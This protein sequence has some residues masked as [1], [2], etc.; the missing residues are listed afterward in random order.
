VTEAKLQ[1]ETKCHC[2]FSLF[3]PFFLL[4]VSAINL[5]IIHAVLPFL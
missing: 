5:F 3:S 1:Q 2:A 4:P